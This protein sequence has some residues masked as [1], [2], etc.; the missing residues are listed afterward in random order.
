MPVPGWSEGGGLPAV[1]GARVAQAHAVLTGGVVTSIVI[2]D[3]GSGYVAAPYVFMRN[4]PLD[5]VGC[6]SP[7]FGSATSGLQLNPGGSQSWEASVVTTDQIAVYGGTT[8]QKF[9]CKFMP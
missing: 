9:T 6:A 2:D 4:S 8:G 1:I 7:F 3:G 5:P